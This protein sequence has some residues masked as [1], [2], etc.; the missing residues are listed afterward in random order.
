MNKSIIIILSVALVLLSAALI[1]LTVW[2]SCCIYG[3]GLGCHAKITTIH[4]IGE[5][6]IGNLEQ[7]AKDFVF[8]WGASEKA[9][10]EYSA[11]RFFIV[12]PLPTQNLSATSP[13]RNTT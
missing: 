9:K 12:K 1:L 6:I 5:E 8:K 3:F 11:D 7:N 4:E 10:S 2:F 13:A